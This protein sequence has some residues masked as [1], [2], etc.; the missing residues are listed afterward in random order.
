MTDVATDISIV[1]NLHNEAG[2]LKR[3]TMSLEDAVSFAASYGLSCEIICVLDR[4]DSA[5][6]A[7]I[8]GHDFSLF[9]SHTILEVDNGSLGLSRNDGV[10]RANGEYI[11][12]CDADD[13]ISYNMLMRMHQTNVSEGPRTVVLAE[14]TYFFGTHFDLARYFGTDKVCKLGLFHYH[15]FVSRIFAH[16]SVF[17]V[18]KFKDVRLSSGFAYEDW[19][20]NCEALTRGCEFRVARQTVLFY[21]RRRG[22]LLQSAN[23]ISIQQPPFSAYYEPRVFTRVCEKDFIRHG[24]KRIFK[25]DPEQVRREIL[26]DHAVLELIHRANTIDPAIDPNKLFDCGIW[27]NVEPS[28]GPAVAYFR[29]CEQLANLTFSHVFLLPFLTTGGADLY[30]LA[31][32]HAL[33]RAE[34]SARIL[35]MFGQRNDRHQWLEKL[36]PQAT[37]MDIPALESS[38]DDAAIRLVALRLIQACAPRAKIFLKACEFSMEFFKRFNVV[39]KENACFYFYFGDRRTYMG[40]LTMTCG[41]N[42]DFLSECGQQLAGV[43]MDCASLITD[44][45]SHLDSMADRMHAIYAPVEPSRR[46]RDYRSKPMVRRILWASRLDSQKRPSVLRAIGLLLERSKLDVTVDVY[47]SAVLGSFDTDILRATPHLD[48]KGGFTDFSALL[49][50]EYDAFLYTSAYDGMPNVVLEAMS[51]GLVVMAPNV[52]GIGEAVTPERGF[53][54]EDDGDDEKLAR[55]YVERIAQLYSNDCDLAAM[56]AAA[57]EL[58]ATR[59]SRDE[60]ERKVATV[61]AFQGAWGTWMP[62]TRM[63]K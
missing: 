29:A 6:K 58:I 21:R 25:Y 16:R 53:L 28:L 56:S 15:P 44:E 23:S 62:Q 55:A 20:F 9:R 1:F 8:E 60:F 7:W 11:Y 59:H 31:V 36:P 34:P 61:V 57:I 24:K 30:V 27:T 3:T 32:L 19:Q 54:V 12:L 35:L 10:A 43:I 33:T 42:F 47:G 51:A 46:R 14:Y 38:L 52:G 26:S 41:Y 50:W 22:S 40:G 4:P 49:P 63:M 37:F 13:L 17:D 48:Y 2:F 39:L 45:A 18:A 5:T